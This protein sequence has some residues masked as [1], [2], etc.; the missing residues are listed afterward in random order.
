MLCNILSKKVQVFKNLYNWDK[1]NTSCNVCVQ[2]HIQI[3]HG[4]DSPF[5][6]AY[7]VELTLPIKSEKK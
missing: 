4:I 5:Q 2:F 7:G 6:L 1:K 3:V